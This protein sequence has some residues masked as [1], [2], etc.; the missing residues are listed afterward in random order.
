MTIGEVIRTHRKKLGIT[1]EEMANR[2]GVT[3]PAVNK[4]EMGRTQP[5]ISLLAPIARLLGITTDI[6][7]SYQE[8]LTEEEL[9]RFVRELDQELDTKPYAEAFAH[10]KEKIEAYPN[11][12]RLIWNLAVI[13]NARKILESSKESK[14]PADNDAYDTQIC[15]WFLR[16][17][18]SEEESVRRS[19]AESLYCFYVRKENYEKA[20]EYL[21]YFSESDP[22]RQRFQAVLHSKTGRKTEAY[23]AYENLLLSTFNRLRMLLNDLHVLY[24]EDG[25]LCMAHKIVDVESGLAALFEMGAYQEASAGLD[26][27]AHEKDVKETERIMRI[28]LES[29]NTLTQFTHSDLCRHLYAFSEKP[30][31]SFTER[32]EKDLL[33]GF[34]D[35]ETFGYMRGNT[36][37]EGLKE[38]FLS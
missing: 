8:E 35:E 19:A 2:L 1:Q 33:Q 23:K 4:W 9:T 20:E 26:L 27:A 5:D 11:C 29:S 34:L 3:A 14:Q 30:A 7:L 17:L 16:A 24:M 6:L 12:H 37:W 31:L 38:T 32:L 13:L 18:E 22:D 25:D 36:F 28:L 21:A 10:A 15:G